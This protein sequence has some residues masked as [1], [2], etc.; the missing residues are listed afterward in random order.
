M[1]AAPSAAAASATIHDATAGLSGLRA[2]A[3]PPISP[4]TANPATAATPRPRAAKRPN[5][6]QMASDR[7]TMPTVRTVFWLSPRFSM[8]NDTIAPGV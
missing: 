2:A 4:N 7:T 5:R 8:L 1:A 3:Q 6:P